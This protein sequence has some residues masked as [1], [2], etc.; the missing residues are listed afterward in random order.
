MDAPGETRRE[1]VD[2][3]LGKCGLR[4]IAGSESNGHLWPPGAADIV[5][6]LG[7]NRHNVESGTGTRQMMDAHHVEGGHGE[8]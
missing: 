3:I 4:A 2:L 6:F 1:H 7:G 8:P 5:G